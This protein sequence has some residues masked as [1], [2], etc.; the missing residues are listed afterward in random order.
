MGV[1]VVHLMDCAHRVYGAGE[2]KVH[3]P[4]D[5]RAQL[6]RV[7]DVVGDA[8]GA[9]HGCCN[10]RKSLTW[11]SGLAQLRDG[12]GFVVRGTLMAVRRAGSA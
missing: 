2:A 9:H 5:D 7:E 11:R 12:G 8:L 3:L 1:N 10:S 6:V 4:L